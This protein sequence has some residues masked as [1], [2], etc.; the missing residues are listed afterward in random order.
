MR[1]THIKILVKVIAISSSLISCSSNDQKGKETKKLNF[2]MSETKFEIE[3]PSNTKLE[4]GMLDFKIKNNDN[5][6]IVITAL[7]DTNLVNKVQAHKSYFETFNI[8]MDS[9]FINEPNGYVAQIRP[10]GKPEF[11]MVYY[12]KHNNLLFQFETLPVYREKKEDVIGMFNACK[13][14]AILT[15]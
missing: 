2:E 9:I 8:K 7:R 4:T 12:L 14:I 13:N 6:G 3:V 11:V 5:F 1:I 10:K 15:K